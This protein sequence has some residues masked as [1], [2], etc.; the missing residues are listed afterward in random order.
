MKVTLKKAAA[1]AAAVSAVAVK[2]DHAY[3]VDIYADP[4]DEEFVTR[5]RDIL[6]QQLG[7]ALALSS[8]VFQLRRLIGVANEGAVNRLLTE[9][10]AIEKQLSIVNS[11]PLRTQGTNLEALKRQIEAGRAGPEVGARLFGARGTTLELETHTIVS[12]LLRSLKREK[13]RVDEE[14]QVANF[15]TEIELPDEVVKVLTDLDLV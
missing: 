5:A 1:L 8:V 4:P 3:A 14:L 2:Q 12:P 13:R 15:T 6:Q 11:I 9:R 7:S 10:A